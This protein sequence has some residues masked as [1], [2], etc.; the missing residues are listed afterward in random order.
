MMGSF[1]KI[2]NNSLVDAPSTSIMLNSL[3]AN[4]KSK[5]ELN[6]EKLV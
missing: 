1:D 6:L 5:I 4:I 3:Q 2:F